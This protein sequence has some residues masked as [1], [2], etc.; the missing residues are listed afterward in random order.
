MMSIGTVAEL[1]V[2]LAV[3]TRAMAAMMAGRSRRSTSRHIGAQG[4]LPSR[5]LTLAGHLDAMLSSMM[6]K[7]SARSNV[8]CRIRAAADVT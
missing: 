2:R 6:A 4:F 7:V 3:G 5:R 8:V 1:R